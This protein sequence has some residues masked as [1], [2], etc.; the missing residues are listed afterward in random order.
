MS[1]QFDLE[2]TRALAGLFAVPRPQRDAD[3]KGRFYA[4]APEA[5]LRS[6]SPQVFQGPDGFPYFFLALPPVGGIFEP[7]CVT[8]ILDYCLFNGAG[9]A[10][11]GND[12]NS[13]EWVFSYGDL[14]SLKAY[15]TFEGDPADER[16]EEAPRWKE[17]VKKQRQI[18]T[19]APTPDYL[20]PLTRKALRLFLERSGVADPSVILAVDPALKPKRHLVFNFFPEDFKEEE[21]YRRLMHRLYWFMPRGRGLLGLQRATVKDWK[22]EPL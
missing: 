9:A 13:A 11:F 8:H 16:M 18:L 17:V 10:L 12:P 19:G 4:A 1:P 14:S 5:S 15:G 21:D 7:F 20:P 6:N 3:W 22:F 2:K